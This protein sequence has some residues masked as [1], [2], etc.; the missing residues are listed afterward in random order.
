MVKTSFL[1][2][3]KI[4][5][6]RFFYCERMNLHCTVSGNDKKIKRENLPEV[7]KKNVSNYSAICILRLKKFKFQL[8]VFNLLYFITVANWFH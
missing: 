3:E 4:V 7:A 5:M 8:V 1:G 2:L 6:C